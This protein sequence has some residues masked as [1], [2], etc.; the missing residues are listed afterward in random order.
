[1]VKTKIASELSVAISRYTVH[2]ICFGLFCVLSKLQRQLKL[3]FTLSGSLY[4]VTSDSQFPT[5]LSLF[6]YPFVPRGCQKLRSLP[7]ACLP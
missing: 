3:R 7:Y 4:H 5:F 2:P 1:M 6:P